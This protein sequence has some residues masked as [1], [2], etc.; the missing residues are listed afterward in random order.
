MADQ[1]RILVA[2]NVVLDVVQKR[3]PFYTDSARVLDAVANQEVTGFLAAHSITT[4]FYV[5]RRMQDRA[6]AVSVLQQLLTTFTIAPVNDPIIR[7]ALSWGWRDFEDAVQMAT[8]VHTNLNYIVSRNS[9]NFAVHLVPVLE[10]AHF[11]TI[12]PPRK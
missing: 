9:K 5:L 11:L 8:A 2:L 10:P 3:Q 1:T 6:T 12:L 7:Q 4:L